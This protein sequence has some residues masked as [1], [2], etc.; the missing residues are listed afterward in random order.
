MGVHYA[1]ARKIEHRD[2]K[3]SNIM[4]A[5]DGS[6]KIMDFGIAKKASETLSR[7]SQTDPTG[8]PAYMAPEQHRGQTFRETDVYAL[9]A[10][11]Y[12][13]IAGITPFRR[14]TDVQEK[15]DMNFERPSALGLPKWLDVVM[16]KGMAPQAKNRY[17]EAMELSQA[18]E[19]GLHQQTPT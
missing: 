14:P 2:L 11:F 6:A 1:H 5:S 15:E 16:E 18:I 19:A 9:T 7:F 13:M 4:V 12:E 3:P 8:T 17:R 10:T